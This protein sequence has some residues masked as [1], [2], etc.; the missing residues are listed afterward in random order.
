MSKITNDGLTRS[1]TGCFT[2]MATMGVEKL[3]RCL[4]AHGEMCH[5]FN[6]LP[7]K[8]YLWPSSVLQRRQNGDI[9]CKLTFHK[10][11]GRRRI[12]QCLVPEVAVAL[13]SDDFTQAIPLHW[14]WCKDHIHR[15]LK[16]Y[17]SRDHQMNL[18]ENTVS[19]MSPV[20]FVLRMNMM[21]S[22]RRM[23][24]QHLIDPVQRMSWSI[25]QSFWWMQSSVS[26]SYYHWTIR[27]NTSLLELSIRRLDVG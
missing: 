23:F 19:S 21:I 9:W 1:G 26:V 24:R 22:R 5:A 6:L 18:L 10:F 3:I 16:D 27:L 2:H 4:A 25:I 17:L 8:S 7:H 12:N 20:C 13:S 14:Q 15:C 11:C